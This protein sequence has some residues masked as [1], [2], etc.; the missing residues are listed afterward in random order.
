MEGVTT[1][2]NQCFWNSRNITLID[3]PSTIT[4]LNNYGIH[5][6]AAS[7]QK[8][9]VVICRA[10]TPPTLGS[11]NYLTNLTAVYVPD[12][13]VSAY[14]TATT[15]SGFAAKIKPLSEYTG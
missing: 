12:D 1:I 13:S 6:Y 11:N 14:K 7:G 10:A 15:W 8:N 3:L 5:T 2:G 9:Y 4:T